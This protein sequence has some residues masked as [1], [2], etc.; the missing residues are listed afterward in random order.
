M[1]HILAS[2]VAAAFTA[3]MD[4]AYIFSSYIHL[5]VLI[6]VN[7]L[8]GTK[9]ILYTSVRAVCICGA[10]SLMIYLGVSTNRQ[11]QGRE[12]MELKM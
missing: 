9:H 2:S 4:S 11:K 3:Y 8:T 7:G 12:G 1:T 10:G 5:L 6:P